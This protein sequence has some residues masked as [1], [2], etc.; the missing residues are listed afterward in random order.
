MPITQTYL[1]APISFKFLTAPLSTSTALTT[2]TMKLSAFVI[3]SGL[4]TG[5][6]AYKL[7]FYAGPNCRSANLGSYDSG[8]HTCGKPPANAASVIITNNIPED[9]K[10]GQN[11]SSTIQ[12][13]RSPLSANMSSYTRGA[14]LPLVKSLRW[15][16]NRGEV[17]LHISE[18]RRD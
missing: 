2:I 15:P 13:S 9:D 8:F 14:L 4:V 11:P 10:R 5:L 7:T 18:Q 12:R 1:P 17:R 3:A 16:H 6:N